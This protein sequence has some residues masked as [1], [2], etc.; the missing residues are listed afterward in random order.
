VNQ[1][2][3]W[4][5]DRMFNKREMRILMVGL[6]A[7]GKTSIL[8][9]LKL[10]KPKKTIP[11]IGFNVETLEYI[12]RNSRAILAQFWRN[13]SETPPRPLQVQEHRVHRVGRRRP[14]EAARAVAPLL[15]Q[16]AGARRNSAQF[17]ALRRNSAQF[18]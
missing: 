2:S 8:Y 11:T 9:R 15:R 4:I 17:C 6:D 16:H 14:G 5:V 3:R 12:A 7:S 18:F 10:G 13:H 1:F